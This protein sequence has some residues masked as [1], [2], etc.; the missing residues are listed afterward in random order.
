MDRLEKPQIISHIEKPVDFS[1]FDAK[2]IPCSAKF[3]VMGS[4]PRGSG[5]IQ[6]Y[7]VSSGDLKLVKEIERSNPMK[8]GTFK[9]SSLRDRYLATGDFKVSNYPPSKIHIDQSQS[10]SSAADGLNNFFF[11]LIIALLC[12]KIIYTLFFLHR[13]LNCLN[14]FKTVF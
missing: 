11:I 5:I 4:R 3:V 10:Y 6:I 2:W 12:E 9:A 1:L 7:E 13:F 8:C 14:Q